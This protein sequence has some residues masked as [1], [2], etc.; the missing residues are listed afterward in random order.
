MRRIIYLFLVPMMTVSCYSQKNE[1]KMEFKS[2]GRCD[3]CEAILDYANAEL[4]ATDTL[5]DFERH[6]PKIKLKGTVYKPDGITPAS[7]VVVFIYHTDLEG[8]YPKRGDEVGLARKQG[9]LRGAVRTDEEGNFSFFTFKPGSYGG[10]AAHIH[11]VVLEPN[12]N[13]YYIDDINFDGDPY[14]NATKDQRNWGGSGVVSLKEEDGLLT[15]E[16]NI[17]LGLNIPDYE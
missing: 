5:P 7:D 3:G 4:P 16:R 15:A 1:N 2:H 12:G 13:Y 9:Y 11:T 8:R 14:L 10:G 6:D 17:F